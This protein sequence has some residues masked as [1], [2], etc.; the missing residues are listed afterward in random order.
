[1]N[2]KTRLFKHQIPAVEKLLPLRVGG[3]FMEMGTGKTRTTIEMIAQRVSRGQLDRVVW[4]CPV[5]LK[6]TTRYE[7]QKHTEIKTADLCVFDERTAIRNLPHSLVYVVGTESTSSSNRVVLAANEL[8]S[9]KTMVV[10]DES[11]YIKGHN[12]LRSRR[13]TKLAERAMYRVIMTGTPISEGVVDLYSQ[14]GFLSKSILGYP[15]FYSF[16]RKHLEYS[17]RHRGLI[18]NTF[19]TDIIADKISPYIYQVTKAECFDLPPK[20]HD[21]TYFYLTNEQRHY[22]QLAKDEILGGEDLAEL[23]SYTIFRLFTAL[24]QIVS[25]HWNRRMPDGSHQLLEFKHDRLDTASSVI[26]G[27][28]EAEKV[29]IWV[30]Y[31]YSLRALEAALVAD[32][33]RSSVAR[34][35]GEL[36]DR[37]RTSELGRFRGNARFLLATP[38][39][40]RFGLDLTAASYS[41]FYENEFK[42]LTRIQSEDRLHRPPQTKPTTNIDIIAA[43][44]I[45]GRIQRAIN[46]KENVVKSFKRKVD[47]VKGEKGKVIDLLREV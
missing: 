41:L 25:G 28:P 4:F 29:V 11:T 17:D 30:K 22:Y 33:G 1:M 5:S 10:V 43:D 14:I 20:L 23:S 38:E 31:L 34:H 39:T 35:Y 6:E 40:G 42:Y 2:L 27:I 12:S 19:D 47:R 37:E 24:Q 45:D 21:E 32:Y 18:V 44:S 9:N 3:L 36:N 8:I 7:L 13:I 46:R 26:R 15:S 16:A